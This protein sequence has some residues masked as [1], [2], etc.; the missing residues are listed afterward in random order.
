M[1]P[2][3]HQAI[4]SGADL[5]DS[6]KVSNHRPCN[7]CKTAQARRRKPVGIRNPDSSR[8]YSTNSALKPVRQSSN[9]N[10]GK[11]R[12]TSEDLRIHGRTMLLASSITPLSEDSRP[13][14]NTAVTF[15]R[16]TDG[17]LK[18]S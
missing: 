4:S 5:P 18:L 13:P 1:R 12:S 2:V 8:C 11:Y 9:G 15:L 16:E 10:D 17:R 7:S 6:S 3:C 14:S